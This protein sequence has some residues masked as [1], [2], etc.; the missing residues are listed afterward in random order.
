MYAQTLFQTVFGFENYEKEDVY[1]ENKPVEN[2]NFNAGMTISSTTLYLDGKSGTL[3]RDN[4][5]CVRFEKTENGFFA[6]YI[7]DF[8]KVYI[9]VDGAEIV[10]SDTAES[11]WTYDLDGGVVSGEVTLALSAPAICYHPILAKDADGYYEYVLDIERFS[12]VMD[13]VLYLFYDCGGTYLFPV[14]S[15][16]V[17]QDEIREMFVRGECA[18]NTIRLVAVEQPDV[19]AMEIEYGIAP[20][21]KYDQAQEGYGT[22]IHDQFTVFAVPASAA[23]DKLQMI[24][25][26][27]EV[28]AS[29][30]QKSVKPAYYEIAMKNRYA[31]RTE[32]AQMLDLVRDN[33]GHIALGAVLGYV[34]K[35]IQIF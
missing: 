27:M 8:A 33:F 20:V 7:K 2:V 1:I 25:A 21:P 14:M 34:G 15:L 11:I 3:D 19:R 5:V 35:G 32:D 26:A 4:A 6:Y 10:Y 31:D 23:A 13:K 29:E 24:G 28:M 17:E 16:N 22:M 9:N 30:S 18:M 12:N